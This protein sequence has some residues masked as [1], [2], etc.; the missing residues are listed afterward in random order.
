MTGMTTAS[1]PRTL[2]FERL[3]F[4]GHSAND[5]YWFILPVVLPLMISDYNLNYA[6]AGGV[7]SL[8][9]MVVA[10]F[11][12][13]FGRLS[14]SFFPT[15]LIGIGFIG[16]SA[17]FLLAASSSTLT[18]LNLS[19][20]LAAVGVS[21]FH[22]AIYGMADAHVQR[23]RGRFFGRFESYGS[24]SVILVLGIS[25]LVLQ[26]Y[27]WRFVIGAAAVPGLAAAYLF[28]AQPKRE[29]PRPTVSDDGRDGSLSPWHFGLFLLSSLLRFVSVMAV[30]SFV[31]T[32]LASRGTLPL[33][34]VELVT[35]AYFLGGF[36]GARTFGRLADRV[37]PFTLYLGIIL[38]IPPLV[39]LF[40]SAGG[41]LASVAVLFLFG[42][43]AIGCIPLQN[44]L[45]R[46]FR[47]SL[48][49]GHAFGVLLGTMTIA[50][51]LSPFLFGLSADALGLA[52]SIRVFSIPSVGAVAILV[53]LSRVV[54]RAT[55]YLREINLS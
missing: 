45:M 47:S 46:R 38:T 22:P 39:F 44:L 28:L 25:A 49:A 17:G 27:S 6:G 48:R 26:T 51:A 3:A 43:G 42:G 4:L 40:P 10:L 50:Q 14:D 31:P 36:V 7:L 2:S 35:G 9:L 30:L 23:A 55:P 41:P 33:G 18:L 19:L 13:L 20:A 21:V 24:G 15:R 5:V 52:T 29:A 8:Y 11:S 53:H 34:A 37:N 16:A 32:F 1:T 12:I 54:R